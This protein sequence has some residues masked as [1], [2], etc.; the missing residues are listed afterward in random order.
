MSVLEKLSFYKEFYRLMK[1]AMTQHDS[2]HWDN[3]WICITSHAKCVNWCGKFLNIHSQM[4][5]EKCHAICISY[6]LG[7]FVHKLECKCAL[8]R[9]GLVYRASYFWTHKACTKAHIISRW[10]VQNRGCMLNWNSFLRENSL[11]IDT[12]SWSAWNSLYIQ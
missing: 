3:R 5:P 10:M 1:T 6:N 11:S 2:L 4:G 8:M 9:T 7:I 12:I